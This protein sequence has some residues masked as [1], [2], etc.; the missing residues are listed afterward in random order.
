M[1]ASGY[2]RRVRLLPAAPMSSEWPCCLHG[3]AQATRYASWE[4]LPAGLAP[5]SRQTCPGL[6]KA[7][8]LSAQA[9]AEQRVWALSTHRS[10]AVLLWARS[11][12]PC[13]GEAA[14]YRS[15]HTSCSWIEP[16][17]K[18]QQVRRPWGPPARAQRA[19]PCPGT[20]PDLA[21]PACNPGSGCGGRSVP[22]SCSPSAASPRQLLGTG[23]CPSRCHACLLCRQLLHLWAPPDR[24]SSGPRC[25]PALS[26]TCLQH[27]AT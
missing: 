3:P 24:S 21:L 17:L 22:E 2:W 27:P 10:S 11:K 19:A 15:C 7:C 23:R 8:K 14:A 4:T 13:A 25:A 12:P 20:P 6:S 16:L 9:C 18:A 5:L 1:V 26:A